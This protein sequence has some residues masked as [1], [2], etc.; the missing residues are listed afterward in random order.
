MWVKIRAVDVMFSRQYGG[1]LRMMDVDYNEAS[2][3]S[4]HV[5]TRGVETRKHIHTSAGF[6]R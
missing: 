5:C 4:R 6:N 1:E 2:G 3:N